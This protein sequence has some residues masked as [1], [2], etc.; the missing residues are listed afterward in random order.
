LIVAATGRRDSDSGIDTALLDYLNF[1]DQS[2]A[3]RD[4]RLP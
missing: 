3:P 2:V 1:H 4:F